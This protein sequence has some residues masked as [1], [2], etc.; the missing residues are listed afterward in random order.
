MKMTPSPNSQTQ[1]KASSSLD[2]LSDEQIAMR[3]QNGDGVIFEELVYRYEKQIFRF[4]KKMCRHQEEAEDATQDSFA[5]AF[6]KIQ[7]FDC[8]R[9]F[10]TWLFTIARNEALNRL[11]KRPAT[12]DQ[13]INLKADEQHQPVPQKIAEQE[14][15]Q[16][17]ESEIQ[18]M[19][20]DA[21]EL[22]T[23]F[24]QQELSVK[25]MA[26]VIGKSEGAIKTGLHRARK[27][28]KV[29]LLRKGLEAST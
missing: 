14:R 9:T 22:L 15:Y 16:V 26:E 3:V 19:P 24:Y 27:L 25:E 20:D 2:V 7:Q 6:Q 23:L 17:L 4:T 18:S 12:N 29:K 8:K 28:L 13:D 1:Q 21:R 10:K 5:K 11:N